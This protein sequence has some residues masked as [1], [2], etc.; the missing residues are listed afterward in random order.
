M[1]CIAVSPFSSDRGERGVQTGSGILA[2][3]NNK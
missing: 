3:I 2:K 1:V